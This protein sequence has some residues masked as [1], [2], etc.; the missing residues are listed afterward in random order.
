MT[1]RLPPLEPVDEDAP[2]WR[3][4]HGIGHP[5]HPSAAGRSGCMVFLVGGLV[6]V[7]LFLILAVVL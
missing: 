5:W 6:L 2:A 3:T 4:V 1:G 7:V